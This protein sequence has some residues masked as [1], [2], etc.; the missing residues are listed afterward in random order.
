MSL[1]NKD[2]KS[3]NSITAEIG[4]CSLCGDL[5]KPQLALIPILGGKPVLIDV[6]CGNCGR[7]LSV[8]K[9]GD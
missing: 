4:K 1:E 9:A 2:I 7:V 6:L 8:T 3:S 5:N